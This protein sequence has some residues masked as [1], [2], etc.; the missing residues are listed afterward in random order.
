MSIT[1]KNDGPVLANVDFAAIKRIAS[2]ERAQVIKGFGRAIGG[3][4]WSGVRLRYSG[5]ALTHPAAGPLCGC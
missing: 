1:N 3:W 5:D 2:V 4:L